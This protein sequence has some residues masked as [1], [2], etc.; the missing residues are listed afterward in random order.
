MVEDGLREINGDDAFGIF[1]VSDWNEDEIGG[2]AS[3]MSGLII[4]GLNVNGV[5][6]IL[7]LFLFNISV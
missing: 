2:G 6:V 5:K 7:L 4:K 3:G 1:D